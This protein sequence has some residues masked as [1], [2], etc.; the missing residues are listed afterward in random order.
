MATTKFTPGSTPI[1]AAESVMRVAPE[2]CAVVDERATVWLYHSPGTD[3]PLWRPTDGSSRPMTLEQIKAERGHAIPVPP[4]FLWAQEWR[5]AA[6][7][8]LQNEIEC[9]DEE[10][11]PEWVAPMT[12]GLREAREAATS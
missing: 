6:Q 5:T 7:R 12:Q 4:Q 10:E 2:H 1:E 3:G 8:L 9:W 11:W